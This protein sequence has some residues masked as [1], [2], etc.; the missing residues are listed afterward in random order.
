MPVA[1]TTIHMPAFLQ[2]SGLRK[3]LG[4]S[5]FLPDVFDGGGALLVLDLSLLTW[6]PVLSW[7]EETNKLTVGL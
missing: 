3:K 7:N 5:I 4:L 1:S 2:G 6:Y